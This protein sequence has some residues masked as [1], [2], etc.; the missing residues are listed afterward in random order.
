MA[1]MPRLAVTLAA[2]IAACQDT[3]LEPRNG[4][5]RLTASIGQSPISYFD[6]TSIVFRVHNDGADTLRLVFGN[7]CQ[8]LLYVTTDSN[9]PVRPGPS[10]WGC[11]NIVTNLTIPPGEAHVWSLL[12]QSG[13]GGMADGYPLTPGRY[14]AFARFVHPDYPMA[15]GII[16]FRV[17]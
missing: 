3:G 13:A 5:L 15:S 6:T 7:N 17:R 11:R 4:P 12:V 16:E 2:L 14:R 10:G 8:L 1:R 9:E